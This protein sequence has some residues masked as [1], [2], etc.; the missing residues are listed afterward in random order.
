MKANIPIL[1]NLYRGGA[2]IILGIVLLFSPDRSSHFLLNIMGFFWLTIGLTILRRG[3]QDARY[4]GKNTARITGLVAILTGILVI[5]RRFTNRWVGE[6]VFFFLL[7]TV[8]LATGLLHMFSEQRIGG[9]K[10]ERQTRIHFLL[11]LFEVLLGGLLILSPERDQ[12]YVYWAAT[13]WAI[14]YGVAALGKGVRDYSS[15]RQQNEASDK[16]IVAKE[17]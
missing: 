7:G 10:Q 13:A 6:E 14:V 12:P 4:P 9:F 17:N 3:D 8:I 2:A 15:S 1:M 5:T 16:E 11:G